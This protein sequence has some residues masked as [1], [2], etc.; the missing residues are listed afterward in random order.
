MFLTLMHYP[1][2]KAQ[3]SDLPTYEDM[4]YEDRIKLSQIHGVYIPADLN[5]VIEEF[6]KLTSETSRNK[7]KSMPEDSAVIKL[8]FSLGRWMS[9]NWG[10]YMGTRLS[11]YLTKMGI[12]HPE[13][14]AHFLI[15]TIHRSLNNRSLEIK[16]RVPV[17]AE[18]RKVEHDERRSRGDTLGLWKIIDGDTTRILNGR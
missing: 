15:V 9:K 12:H 3:S 6:V 18:K 5:E 2:L 16:E 11:H 17:Y 10:L 1:D 13:D 14:M 4:A 7:F 8:Y